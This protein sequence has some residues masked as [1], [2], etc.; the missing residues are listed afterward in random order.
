M[1]TNDKIDPIRANDFNFRSQP[2]NPNTSAAIEKMKNKYNCSASKF[3][4]INKAIIEQII[5]NIAKTGLSL[6]IVDSLT[7]TS[8]TTSACVL[9]TTGKAA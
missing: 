6:A 5:D 9:L 1:P 2:N 8:I 3:G 4:S 7:L